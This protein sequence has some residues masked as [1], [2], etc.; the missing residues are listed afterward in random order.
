M[1]PCAKLGG[2][3][4]PRE[5]AL[6][7]ALRGLK[8]GL[9]ARRHV[10]ACHKKLVGHVGTGSCRQAGERQG[11]GKLEGV[12]AVIKFRIR[13]LPNFFFCLSDGLGLFLL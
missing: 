2:E 4:H 1:I 10:N 13:A 5:M 9:I 7:T 3:K 8:T 12:G 6:S 11:T